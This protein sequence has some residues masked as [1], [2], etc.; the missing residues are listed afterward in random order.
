MAQLDILIL[1]ELDPTRRV[2]QLYQPGRKVRVRKGDTSLDGTNTFGAFNN[3]SKTVFVT[4]IS[5]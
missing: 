3:G 2:H 5:M 1:L 4:D